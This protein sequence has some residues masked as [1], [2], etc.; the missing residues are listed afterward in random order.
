MVDATDSKSVG[1]DTVRVQVPWPVPIIT[2][3]WTIWFNFS[4]VRGDKM[5]GIT[6]SLVTIDEEMIRELEKVRFNAYHMDISELSPTESFSAQQL[7]EGEYIAFAA[8]SK[9]Q[10]IGGCYV[11]NNYNS[12]FIEQLFI[13]EEFQNKHIGTA[14]LAYTLKHKDIIQQYFNQRFYYSYLDNLNIQNQMY[15]KLGY[16]ETDS[17]L[18]KKHL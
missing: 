2:M 16:V 17:Y 1:S 10:I 4:F 11:S 12:L 15:Q 3:N 8:L 5:E 7:R 18:M 9:Q 6:F 14:L 13:K